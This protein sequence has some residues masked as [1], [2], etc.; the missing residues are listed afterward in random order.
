MLVGIHQE[1]KLR[2]IP[3]RL[4]SQALV[5]ACMVN[6]GVAVMAS[7]NVGLFLV[8]IWFFLII[9]KV[10]GLNPIWFDKPA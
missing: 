6:Y 4:I 1:G 3:P 7:I 10:E 5:G 9:R 2:Q 8:A